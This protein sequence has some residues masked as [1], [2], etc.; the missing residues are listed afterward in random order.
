MESVANSP[1]EKEVETSEAEMSE[2]KTLNEGDQA[3]LDLMKDDHD[4]YADAEFAMWL[5]V[6]FME[7][8]QKWALAGFV[9]IIPVVWLLL[10]GV[11]PVWALAVITAVGALAVGAFAERDVL[12]LGP[13]GLKLHKPI[14]SKVDEGTPATIERTGN[15]VTVNGVTYAAA[16]EPLE[17]LTD[18]TEA[19]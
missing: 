9:V 5:K 2:E 18:L 1:A 3:L 14:D 8:K 13:D 6:P 7:S 12:S 10:S 15:K 17:T 4:L 16:R 11:L 19:A